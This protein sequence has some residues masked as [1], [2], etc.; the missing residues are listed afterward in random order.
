MKKL[1]HK[2]YL[3]C[4]IL[5][6]L[7]GDLLGTAVLDQT[8]ALAAQNAQYTLTFVAGAGGDVEPKQ[9]IVDD[10]TTS[11][12]SSA[13]PNE[14]YNLV[15]WQDNDGRN[16]PFEEEGGVLE[17][18]R[19]DTGWQDATYTAIFKKKLASSITLDP[20]G[21]IFS[22]TNKAD[23]LTISGYAGDPIDQESIAVTRAGYVFSGWQ[24]STSGRVVSEIKVFPLFPAVYRATWTVAPDPGPQPGPPPA[25]EPQQQ[26][27]WHLMSNGQWYYITQDGARV[28]SGWMFINGAWYYFENAVMLQNRWIFTDHWYYLGSSGAMY[29][30]CWAWIG[31]S[32]YGFW[33][34]GAMCQG[35]VFDHSVN[36]YYYCDPS[37]GAMYKNCWVWIGNA[38]YGF[39]DS[40]E[41]CRGWVW[42]S[43]WHGW[44]YCN[45]SSGYMYRAGWY[46]IGAKPYY[47]RSSGVL[48][49]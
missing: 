23:P 45:S 12:A 34:G 33:W 24:D 35:W 47:F 36:N 5:V 10:T 32:W 26:P 46:T 11:A 8:S 42:D 27:G 38:W 18:V 6:A 22:A 31:N 3:V 43:A 29:N 17:L 48:A 20:A 14:G 21:G 4:L 19:P 28:I 40:G 30:N 2:A 13:T 15:A 7:L 49:S 44:F 9:I 37:S 41:M 1:V 25:P 39:W 16:L